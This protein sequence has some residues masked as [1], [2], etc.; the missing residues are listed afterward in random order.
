MKKYV[1]PGFP[2]GVRLTCH[3]FLEEDLGIPGLTV[4][5]VAD[6]ICPK[7]EDMG[8]AWIHAS[9]GRIGHTPDHASRRSMSREAS[10][11]S[12]RK[13]SSKRFGFLS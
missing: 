1:G 12:L 5:E 10:T 7:L 3:E 6:E 9:A 4:D 11:L 8:V 2:L 13:G